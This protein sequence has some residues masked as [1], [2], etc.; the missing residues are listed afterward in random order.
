VTRLDHVGYVS[1]QQKYAIRQH[2]AQTE[3]IMCLMQT[4]R[5][6]LTGNFN[7]LRTSNRMMPSRDY[8]SDTNAIVRNAKRS[9]R[10]LDPGSSLLHECNRL[11]HGAGRTT[12][13]RT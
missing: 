13:S 1:L 7:A 9:E 5:I 3:H 12:L 8:T 4:V 11:F 6:M 2:Y 10:V